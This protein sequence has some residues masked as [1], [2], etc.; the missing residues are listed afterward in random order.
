IKLNIFPV[1]GYSSPVTGFFRHLHYMILPVLSLSGLYIAL[2]AR[3]T[4]TSVIDC[5]Q[6]DFIRTARSKG[7]TRFDVILRHA[8]PNASVPIL[9]IIGIS[10]TI[11][12][13]GVVVTESVF[14]IP[15]L[16]RLAV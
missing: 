4:R 15:G 11:M 16:G 10:I 6:E 2:I 13:G 9:T 1:Q 7:L 12:I 3:F 14:N 5:L 8:L